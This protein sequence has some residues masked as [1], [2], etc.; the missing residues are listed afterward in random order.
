MRKNL[1]FL[2]LILIILTGCTHNVNVAL[3][4]AYSAILQPGNELS[5]LTPETTFFKGE[6]SDSRPDPSK[7]A[8]FKQGVHTFDLREGRLVDDVF[9]EGLEVLI[10][11]SGHLWSNTGDGDVKINLQFVNC[12]AVRNTGLIMVGATSGIQ[13]KLDFIDAKTGDMIY[14]SIYNGS[15]E[16]SQALIGFMDMVKASIDTSII[17][18]IQS[19]GNDASLVAAIKKF[20]FSR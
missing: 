6:F 16:R 11:T 20:L 1:V 3:R 19:V 8:S 17:R 14:S 13:I 7:L 5:K 15:D 10:T 12:Q 9:Y 18:C 4:P 2:F